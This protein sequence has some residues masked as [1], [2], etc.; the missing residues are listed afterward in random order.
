NL[1]SAPSSVTTLP[2]RLG[3][4][5]VRSS[6][7]SARVAPLAF[8]VAWPP[9]SW[10]KMVG[11]RTSTGTSDSWDLRRR[12]KFRLERS[13]LPS[14]ENH[15]LLGDVPV[16]DAVRTHDGLLVP[17]RDQHVVPGR[18]RGLGDVGG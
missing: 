5:L 7:T 16:D 14:F 13:T 4:C 18:V 3:N 1:C 17:Q 6:N 8:T 15:R 9:A 10:R 11:R 12:N 2:A